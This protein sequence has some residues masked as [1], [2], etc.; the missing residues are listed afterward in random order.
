M[1]PPRRPSDIFK[2]DPLYDPA[3]MDANYHMNEF[4]ETVCSVTMKLDSSGADPRGKG[5]NETSSITDVPSKIG[6]YKIKRTLGRGAFGTVYLG[7]DDRLQRDVAIKIPILKSSSKREQAEKEFLQEARQV[8]QVRHPNVVTVHDVS[9]Y[10][11]TC[12]IVSEFLDGVDL[13]HWM[14]EH[15]PTWEEA[16][17]IVAAVADGLAA[18]H[19]RGIVHRDVKPSNVLMS[20]RSGVEVPVLVDFGM[21]LSESTMGLPGR[22]RGTIAGTPNFMSPEQARGE[23]HRIDGR[24][25]IY[26][27]G[28]IL[29]RMLCGQLPFKATSISELLQVVIEDEPRPLRQFVRGIPPRLEQICQKAMAKQLAD[30]YSTAADFAED[31]RSLINDEKLAAEQ[32]KTGRAEKKKKKKERKKTGVKILI[33]EDNE[34][35]R[36][37]LQT[38]L[39]RWGHDVIAAEDGEKA[40]E[41]FQKDDFSIVITDWMMPN[42]SGLE[43]VQ[44]IRADKKMDYVYV[45]MLTAKS[46]K[47]DIVAG[48][49]AGADDFLAKPFHRDELN[50]RLRAGLRIVKM[51]RDLN[52]AYRRMRS[53]L[54]AAARIQRSYLP[55]NLPAVSGAEFAWEY[56]PS[57]ELGGDMLNVVRLGGNRVGMYVLDV[58]GNGVPASLLAT[59]LS[60]SLSS[61]QDPSSLLFERDEDDELGEVLDPE[62]VAVRLNRRFASS[63]GSSEF[64]TLVYGILDTAT[65]EF[66]YVSA[67]HPPILL[68]RADGGPEMLEGGGLPIGMAPENE[69]YYQESVQLARGDRLML[70]S[71]GLGD[72]VNAD[73]QLFGSNRFQEYAR[74]TYNKPLDEMVK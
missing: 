29:Y 64:F 17:K 63:R 27:A 38:D 49:G 11:G 32:G 70:Y 36:F 4:G 23:G 3:E 41:L 37:K 52:D 39:E 19:E 1:A 9:V 58:N 60:R 46:E 8:V 54:E 21:A 73:D 5:E 45:L 2:D 51:N 57:A 26:A 6:R 30:R 47:H 10:E 18:A 48:M 12:Y 43:L 53:G 67:G 34:V 25:D 68:Q 20:Q 59:S 62:E 22:Q 40:W 56:S 50:V 44:K 42:V 72:A 16:A 15:T 65:R 7:F 69:D 13:N 35:T 66:T 71:D 14:L 61:A 74:I 55:E 28:V 33:A 31:L 24:S